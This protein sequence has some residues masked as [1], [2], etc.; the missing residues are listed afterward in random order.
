MKGYVHSL[1][2][3]GT[4]DGPGVRAVLFTEGCPLRCAYCHNPDTWEMKE[5]SLVG[6]EEIAERIIRLYPYIKNGGVTFSGGEPCVQAEFLYE[7][8]LLLKEKKLHIALDT[9]GCILDE[10]TKK[11]LTATDMVLLDVKMTSEEDYGKYIGGSLGK[12][13]DFLGYLEKKGIETHIRH[14]VVPGINDTEEDIKKL[15]ELISPYTCVSKT[16]LLPFRT[17][18]L[19][20]YENMGIEFPLKGTEQMDKERL[21][22]LAELI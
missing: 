17:L 15:R 13:M 8:A 20:K 14:V 19:E 7:V 5:E 16:E 22:K 9:S 12:T 3:M 4:V 10:S 21:Q 1:Q 6:A 2:S 18:C 11:L